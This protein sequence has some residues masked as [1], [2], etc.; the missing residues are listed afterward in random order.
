MSTNWKPFSPQDHLKNGNSGHLL[1]LRSQWENRWK[2]SEK[3]ENEIEGLLWLHGHTGQKDTV[4]RCC[5]GAPNTFPVARKSWSSSVFRRVT[6][7]AGLRRCIGPAVHSDASLSIGQGNSFRGQENKDF[8][9]QD[10]QILSNTDRCTCCQGRMG[11]ERGVRGQRWGLQEVPKGFSADT[12]QQQR[13]T[14]N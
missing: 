8:F 12:F 6:T 14:K 1:P 9:P 4:W 3:K 13:G 7:G 10:Y 11:V 5:L 2:K